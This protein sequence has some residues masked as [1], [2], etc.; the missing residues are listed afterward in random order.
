MTK[1]MEQAIAYVESL[2]FI[3]D[4]NR[5]IAGEAYLAGAK[6]AFERAADTAFEKV[7]CDDR[8]DRWQVASEVA[9][10][11]RDLAIEE[12]REVEK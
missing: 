4:Q 6:A 1:L 10:H 12:S 5:R 9:A 3:D 7:R 11:I 2:D 8:T